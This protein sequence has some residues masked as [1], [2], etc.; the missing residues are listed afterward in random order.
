MN[1]LLYNALKKP[2]DAD[3][4]WALPLR[5]RAQENF[6]F[7]QTTKPLGNLVKRIYRANR[8]SIHLQ[9]ATAITAV[10]LHYANPLLLYKLIRYIEDPSDQQPETG[11]LYCAAIF[12]FNILSTLVA[13]QTLMWG[14]RWHITMINMLNSEIYAHTLRLGRAGTKD[15]LK[16]EDEQHADMDDT[17]QNRRASLLSHDTERLAELASYLHVSCL[18]C[19]NII[20]I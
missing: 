9:F 6:R 11:Y 2:L 16:M 18:C 13:S 14:R 20:D 8:R 7:F 3:Q 1:S 10:A 4:L 12:V 17:S 5:Q 19:H 15:A